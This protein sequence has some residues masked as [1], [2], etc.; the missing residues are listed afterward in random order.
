MCLL[1]KP[2][3]FLLSKWA[4]PS[5]RPLQR[6]D[7]TIKETPDSEKTPAIIVGTV[8][9]SLV[10]N[11]KLNQSATRHTQGPHKG[12]N[13]T[14]RQPSNLSDSSTIPNYANHVQTR[15]HQFSTT[16]SPNSGTIR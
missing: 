5:R 8:V 9:G 12:P 2:T 1:R 16:Y 14:T 7:P 11:P 13:G 4:P 6:E 3:F 15:N 10:Q